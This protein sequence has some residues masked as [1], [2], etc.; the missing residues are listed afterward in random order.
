MKCLIFCVLYLA[1]LISNVYSLGLNASVLSGNTTVVCWTREG[2]DPNPLH[3]DLRYIALPCYDQSVEL[4]KCNPSLTEFSG[5]TTVQLPGAGSYILVALSEDNFE[6]GRTTEIEIPES[7]TPSQV[8]SQVPTQSPTQ[9][10]TQP[11]SQSPS[12]TP[13][14]TIL[15]SSSKAS[16][17]LKKKSNVAAIILALFGGISLSIILLVTTVYLRRRAQEDDRRISF[18]G[19][20]MVQGDGNY[21]SA[22]RDAGWGGVMPY[23]SKRSRTS[24]GSDGSSLLSLDIE[25]GLAVP[26]PAI[27]R[28]SRHVSP[29]PRTPLPSGYVVPPPRGPRDRTNSVRRIETPRSPRTP[30]EPTSRQKQLSSRLTEVENDIRRL[31]SHPRP[32]P[33]NVVVLED[34]ELQKSWLI[35]QRYSMWAMEEIDTPPPGHSRYMRQ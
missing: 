4:A 14:L 31:K 17:S 23:N 6:L 16:F 22:G 2:L 11:P 5:N 34:L 33:S 3:F 15:P 12:P 21:P 18:H 25:R 10:P 30:L 7:S 35:K 26:P 32:L 8:S 24:F 20:R 27:T 19:E 28:T 29:I 13:S 1:S 9:V